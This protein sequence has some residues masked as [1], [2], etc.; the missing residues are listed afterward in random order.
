MPQTTAYEA[1]AA[2]EAGTFTDLTRRLLI[3]GLLDNE[4]G[5]NAYQ[6]CPADEY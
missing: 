6:P 2:V 1:P 5:A 4:T 3:A